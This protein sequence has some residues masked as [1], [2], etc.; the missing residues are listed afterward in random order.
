[1]SFPICISTISLRCH[2]TLAKTSSLYWWEMDTVNALLSTGFSENTHIFCLTCSCLWVCHTVPL[3]MWD[4][5]IHQFTLNNPA[6]NCWSYLFFYKVRIKA[7]VLINL[8]QLRDRI[9]VLLNGNEVKI[10]PNAFCYTYRS[11]HLSF[12]IQRN[13]LL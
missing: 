4:M 11:I 6:K 1:M 13:F 3:F 12:F 9:K 2:I 5:T 10:I 7:D 8:I